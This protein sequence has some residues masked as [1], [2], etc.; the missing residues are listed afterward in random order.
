MSKQTKLDFYNSTLQRGAESLDYIM[1]LKKVIFT[2]AN[3]IFCANEFIVF[4]SGVTLSLI[5]GGLNILWGLIFGAN[6]G[7]Y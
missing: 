1:R 4:S 5:L 6:F 3:V 7:F 2:L